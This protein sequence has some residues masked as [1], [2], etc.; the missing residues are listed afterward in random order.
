MIAFAVDDA[1]MVV[2]ILGIFYGGRDYEGELSGLDLTDQES[3]DP[4]LGRQ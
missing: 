3:K 1:S 4:G 2:S